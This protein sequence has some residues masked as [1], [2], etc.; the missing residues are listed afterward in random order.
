MAKYHHIDGYVEESYGD[1]RGLEHRRIMGCHIGRKL[2]YDE[3]VHHKNG[4]RN[5]NRIENLELMSRSEHS[6]FHHNPPNPA[7]VC[8]AYCG[9]VFKVERSHYN[10]RINHNRYDF[11]CS[12]SCAGKLKQPPHTNQKFDCNLDKIITKELALGKTGYQIAIENGVNKKTV[13]TH[14]HKLKNTAIIDM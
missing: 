5:D 4:V 14:I 10:Y 8:C 13:Y 1:D 6:R 7:R 9:I 2:E 3:V 12:R 11:Y